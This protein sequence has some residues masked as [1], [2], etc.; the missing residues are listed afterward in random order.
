VTVK[1]TLVRSANRVLRPFGAEIV[2]AGFEPFHD[3]RGFIPFEST[4]V[5]A[6]HAGV[7]VGD[8]IDSHHN[9]AGAT[10]ATID[11]LVRLG[12]IHAGVTQV[13]ELGPGSGRYLE[14]VIHTCKPAVYEIYETALQ[15]R[16]LVDSY[17]VMGHEA[18]G[19]SL[20][21][22]PSDSFDLVHAHKVFPGLPFVAACRYLQEMTRIAARGGHVVFDVVTEDC[23]APE[24]LE[25]WLA[26]EA[27]YQ[28]YPNLVPRRYLCDLLERLGLALVGSFRVP[29]KPGETECFAFV[30]R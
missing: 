13:C 23:M 29:M 25:R 11:E 18:D 5:E 3:Y 30:K 7:P 27:D 1:H 22:S 24:V 10:Q 19:V 26:A 28:V 16:Y 15:W 21:Q 2:R 9:V 14:K 20:R 4:M 17:A 6:Q 8:Y 12:A